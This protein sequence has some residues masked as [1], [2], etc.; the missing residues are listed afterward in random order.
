M[1]SIKDSGKIFLADCKTVSTALKDSANESF[2]GIIPFCFDFVLANT[3]FAFSNK[4][5]IILAG[6]HKPT[7]SDV[8]RGRFAF[9]VRNARFVTIT[10]YV[11]SLFFA[12]K[13]RPLQAD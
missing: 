3:F 6:P 2:N 1:G 8:T 4:R 7:P 13:I 11:G 5:K 12:R 10:H 9:S